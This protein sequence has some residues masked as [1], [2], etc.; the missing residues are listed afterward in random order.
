MSATAVEVH[1]RRSGDAATAGMATPLR[2]WLKEKTYRLLKRLPD[3]YEETDLEVL[4][5]C[6]GSV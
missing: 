2:L 4:K 1:E 6:P 3:H 5:R